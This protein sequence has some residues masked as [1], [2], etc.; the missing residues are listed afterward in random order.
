MFARIFEG[1]NNSFKILACTPVYVSNL[2]NVLKCFPLMFMNSI[3]AVRFKALNNLFWSP[4]YLRVGFLLLCKHFN[5]NHSVVLHW[6]I[7][8]SVLNSFKFC[9]HTLFL[10]TKSISRVVD[11]DSRLQD[12]DHVFGELTNK[13]DR[14]IHTIH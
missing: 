11:D 4:P 13:T 9:F 1:E 12:T 7:N 6:H 8:W 2:W 14:K 10:N 5:A 3:I